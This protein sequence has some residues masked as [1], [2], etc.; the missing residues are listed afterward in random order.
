MPR[1]YL[2]KCSDEE[3][4][5]LKEL[6]MKQ[7][8]AEA[9]KQ[10]ELAAKGAYD[11]AP[12]HEL[13]LMPDADD[14]KGGAS[15]RMKLEVCLMRLIFW[16][17]FGDIVD[18]TQLLK[19][20]NNFKARQEAKQRANDGDATA[21]EEFEKLEMERVALQR[22]NAVSAFTPKHYILHFAPSNCRLSLLSTG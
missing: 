3:Q 6:H 16:C 15:N 21:Q 22:Q 18:I 20:A 7:R 5:E 12:D 9:Q 17:E 14:E 11:V 10:A 1:N 8:E 2:D 13:D 19:R 4:L